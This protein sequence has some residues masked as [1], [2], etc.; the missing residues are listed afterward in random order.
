MA[1]TST[2]DLH[3]P[4]SN[5]EKMDIINIPGIALRS[6]IDIAEKNLVNGKLVQTLCYLLGPPKKSS[7]DEIW[8]D[9]VV[10]PKQTGTDSSVEDEGIENGLDKWDTITA[11]RKMGATRNKNIVAWVH[12]RPPGPNK[13]EFTSIDMHNQFALTKYVSK[14][15]IG[16][17]V[18]IRKDDFIWNAM[19][20]N[21]FGEQRVDFC[22]KKYNCPFE[23][24][25]WCDCD[26]LYES[27]RSNVNLCKEIPDG[28][29]EVILANFMVKIKNGQSWFNL[30]VEPTYGDS[31]EDNPEDEVTCENC[32][33]KFVQST[34][35]MHL[36][37]RKDCKSHYGPRF[38]DMK[39]K[40]NRHKKRKSRQKL[41]T[42]HELKK[43]REAYKRKNEEA[44]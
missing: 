34:I 17:V 7:K 32:D 42:E 12:T 37:H 6:F 4:G 31:E 23:L 18:E 29:N 13:C 20:L 27:C 40:K 21:V 9:T 44:E 8:I 28:Q 39:R 11:L 10:I 35:L 24:H 30:A 33:K 41:G 3:P 15:I 2:K 38:E 36:S 14:D 5:S 26:C 19:G 22:G 25:K 16:I 1:T 43:N